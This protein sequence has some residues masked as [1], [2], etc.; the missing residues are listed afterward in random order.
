[1]NMMYDNIVYGYGFDPHDDSDTSISMT[2]ECGGNGDHV[3]IAS[4][5]YDGLPIKNNKVYDS[6]NAVLF[7][8]GTSDDAIVRGKIHIPADH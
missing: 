5:R 8:H 6:G 1:M 3:I 4:K 7:L 2:T